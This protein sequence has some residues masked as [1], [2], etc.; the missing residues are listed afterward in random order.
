MIT[1]GAADLLMGALLLKNS[2]VDNGILK[3]FAIITII[4]GILK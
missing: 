1:F 4:Q 2:D 3:A